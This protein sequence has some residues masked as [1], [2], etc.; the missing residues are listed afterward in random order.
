MQLFPSYLCNDYSKTVLTGFQQLVFS[1]K[2][3]HYSGN[4]YSRYNRI[5]FSWWKFPLILARSKEWNR[6]FSG[7][8]AF[9]SSN[10]VNILYTPEGH[11]TT[12][13]DLI[14]DYRCIY[15]SKQQSFFKFMVWLYFIK[16]YF[17]ASFRKALKAR[18]KFLWFLFYKAFFFL[19]CE[20]YPEPFCFL[21]RLQ[22]SHFFSVVNVTAGSPGMALLDDLVSHPDASKLL[23]YRSLSERN[24]QQRPWTSWGLHNFSNWKSASHRIT[25]FSGRG[26]NIRIFMVTLIVINS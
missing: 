10:I 9:R 14:I 3:I 22:Q 11:K 5:Q 25:D 23:H 24:P 6:K 15:Y 21:T 4:S 13:P 26:I 16:K 18:L 1:E 8:M 2:T 20:W 19:P 7:P 12:K 17:F